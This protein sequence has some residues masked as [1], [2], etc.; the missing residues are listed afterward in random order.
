MK[1]REAKVFP[2]T[3]I[4]NKPTGTTVQLDVIILILPLRNQTSQLNKMEFICEASEESKSFSGSFSCCSRDM[5]EGYVTFT[6]YVH[7]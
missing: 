2:H 7:Y 6:I 1:F 5:L 3:K 4:L